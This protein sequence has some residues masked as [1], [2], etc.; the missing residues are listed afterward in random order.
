MG[1][2]MGPLV[3]SCGAVEGYYFKLCTLAG[4]VREKLSLMF[5]VEKSEDGTTR[6][7]LRYCEN[8]VCVQSGREGGGGCP[9][10]GSNK[11]KRNI[12]TLGVYL[13]VR[14]SCV[15]AGEIPS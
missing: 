1:I 12:L 15:A 13:R 14:L 6:Q 9:G 10:Q 3:T 5:S 8:K 7:T 11:V 4:L 2:S